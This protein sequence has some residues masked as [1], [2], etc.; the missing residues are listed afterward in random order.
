M[1]ELLY[2][3]RNIKTYLEYLSEF[4]PGT[5]IDI[6]LKY[7]GMTRYEVDD[8]GHWF[9]QQQIDRFYEKVVQLTGNNNIAR[10]AGRFAAVSEASQTVRK[11]ALGFIGPALAYS[12]VE[13]LAGSTS[14]ATK[15][16]TSST[17]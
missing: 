13:K 1:D 16:K 4:H 9:S 17:Y 15:F 14:K 7:A 6:I 5:D 11:Y 8:E 2:N 3:S 12:M 10:E